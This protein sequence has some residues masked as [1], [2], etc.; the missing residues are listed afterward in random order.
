MVKIYPG[1]NEL[2]Y[3]DK[4][5]N[6]VG[7][8]VAFSSN[9]DVSI[10]ANENAINAV[11]AVDDAS[12]LALEEELAAVQAEQGC[13][14]KGWDKLKGAVNLGSSSEKCDEAIEKYKNGEMT[15]E[16]AM[17][18]IEKFDTK[19]SNSLDL[20]ANIAT[21][22]G[23]VVAATAAAAAIVAS[24]G[25]ATPLVLA[26]VGAGTGALTKASVKTVDRATNDVK[27]DALNGKQIAKD[28]ISGGITGS[29]GALT[30]GTGSAT[31]SLGGSVAKSAV[32]SMKTGAV[33]G[34]ISGS[35]NYLIE[36]AFEEDKKFNTKDFLVSTATGTV[37]GT[38]VG[39]I[40]GSSYGAMKYSGIVKHG[41]SV[42]D[43]SGQYVAENATKAA[44][45]D[46]AVNNAGYKVA[47]RAVK[48]IGTAVAA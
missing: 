6:N 38:T 8:D 22:V 4:Q 48:D 27:D 10:F 44:V 26:A 19:Q 13:I 23:A 40:M 41:G 36:T 37:V 11:S 1:Y 12:I 25:T 20:F 29:I 47:T 28:A 5:Q 18:E 16:E 2:N 3:L 24:G 15:F 32:K 35:S 33:T 42:I 45:V 39:G 46:N 14:M 34:S 9:Q 31:S 17:A 30:M 21:G 7:S 43:K